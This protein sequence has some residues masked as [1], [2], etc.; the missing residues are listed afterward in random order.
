MICTYDKVAG[1]YDRM[2][3]RWLRHAGGEA[4]AALE[5]ALTTRIAP[6]DRVLDAGCGTGALSR[7]LAR[8]FDDRLSLTMLDASRKMLDL[9]RDVRG[10]HVLGSLLQLPFADGQFDIAFAAWSIEA[11]DDEGAA[12]RELMR[13]VRPGGHVVI[14]FCARE[15]TRWVVA[16]LLRKGVEL[17]RTGRFLNAG[18]IETTLH[19][20]GADHIIRHRCSGPVAVIDA[21]RAAAEPLAR[22]A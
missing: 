4:Q 7:S 10:E 19:S 6:G 9:A 13:V 3:G 15:P 18:E 16:N 11:T 22:A 2:H 20:S 17:R 21:R 12:L 5:A 1:R 8:R 14:A